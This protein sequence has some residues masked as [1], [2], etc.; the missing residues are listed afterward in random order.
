[1]RPRGLTARLALTYLAVVFLALGAVNLLVLESLA[2]FSLRQREVAAFTATN[3]GV[4]LVEPFFRLGPPPQDTIG[5][6]AETARDYSRQTGARVLV[7]DPAGKVVADSE[8]VASLVGQ[9]LNQPEVTA[10]LAGR[11]SSGRRYLENH[12]WILY[13]VA[14][15]LQNKAPVGAVFL[16][17]SLDDLYAGLWAVARTMATMSAAALAFVALVGVGV[18]RTITR[19]VLLLTRAAERLGRGRFDQRVPVRGRDEVA[20]LART[21]N[22]MA[23]RLHRQDDERREF[24][25]DVAHELQTPVS[26]IR[27]MA[28]PLAETPGGPARPG[29]DP[30]IYRDFAR[31]MAGQAERLG[32]LVGD[33]LELARLDSPRVTLSREEIDLGQLVAGVVRRLEPQAEAAGVRL[34]A[35]LT[36]GISL[37]GDGLRLEQVFS[38]LIVNAIKYGGA[39]CSVR[40]SVE[41][42][43]DRAVA[44]IEDDGPGIPSR[45]LPH[46]FER[47]YRAEKSRSRQGGG[48][49]LGLAIVRR[50]VE[51]HGG[52]IS[53]ASRSR[54]DGAA[55]DRTGTLFTITLPPAGQ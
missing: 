38:N 20:T 45:H 1:M 54:E 26:A 9:R 39:G 32:R 23:E 16:S 3:I 40:V 34:E 42:R 55:A 28:E 30:A 36:A 18:A 44:E 37:R 11:P 24:L 12:G 21:F 46:I 4:N 35:D 15:V 7:L 8:R 13:T 41:R 48:T 52:E 31:E 17:S 25:A 29:H 19:P 14:P 47:F 27:A 49:G 50:I 2:S 53:V 43:G 51:L 10:A 22:D 6:L 5:Q 33:L